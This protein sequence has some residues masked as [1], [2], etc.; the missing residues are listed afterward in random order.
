MDTAVFFEGIRGV[1]YF[2]LLLFVPGFA[3]SLIIFPRP[4]SLSIIDRLVYSTVLGISSGIAIVLF[5]Y[6]MPGLDT[7]PAN[8]ILVISVFS[9]LLLM[10]WG[11]ERWYLN[12]RQKKRKKPQSS[13]DNL[14]PWSYY[15]RETNT[16]T[17]QFRQDTRTITAGDIPVQPDGNPL[18]R[19]VWPGI[20][21]GGRVKV[22][23]VQIRDK[24]QET[25]ERPVVP[26][27]AGTARIK[28][29]REITTGVELK[30]EPKS[31]AIR[32]R[33]LL[34]DI[35][36]H[37]VTPASVEPKKVLTRQNVQPHVVSNEILKHD[38][39]TIVVESIKKLQ[40]DILRDLDMFYVLPDS[41]KRSRENIENIRIP[42]KSDINKKLAEVQEELKDLDW[43]Y[44]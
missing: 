39:T 38:E 18:Q 17:D 7:T 11:C 40:K 26:S 24:L 14:E 8:M 43:L 25:P 27:D 35:H 41:F 31:P 23:K 4:A 1:F 34:K 19:E 20:E 21:T 36:E 42:D 6:V 9:V 29:A 10:F 33:V 5:M 37:L 28:K 30:K 16:E 3:L 44:E 12:N 32:P 22:P 13:S 2:F 15:S